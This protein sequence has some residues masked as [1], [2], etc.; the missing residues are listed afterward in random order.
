[1]A[2]AL[3]RW[4]KIVEVK[5]KRTGVLIFKYKKVCHDSKINANIS[6]TPKTKTIDNL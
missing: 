5:E 6:P 1:V 4:G 2:N 3:L